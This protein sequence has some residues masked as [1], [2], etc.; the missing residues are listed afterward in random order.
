MPEPIYAHY[1]PDGSRV[2]LTRTGPDR[3]GRQAACYGLWGE[4]AG[5]RCEGLSTRSWYYT[6][7]LDCGGKAVVNH[8]EL[9]VV[10]LLE[11]LAWEASREPPPPP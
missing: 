6:I 10:S 11:Q 1:H 2:M 5:L 3:S 7:K 8:N 9:Y 4:I